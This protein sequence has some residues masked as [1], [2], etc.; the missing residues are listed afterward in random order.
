MAQIT[1]IYLLSPEGQRT[2]L[3]AGRNSGEKQVILLMSPDHKPPTP[4][5]ELLAD[6]T[7]K[8]AQMNEAGAGKDMTTVARSLIEAIT[9]FAKVLDPSVQQDVTV[10]TATP[11]LWAQ[12]VSIAKMD[13]EGTCLLPIRIDTEHL[14]ETTGYTVESRGS[15]GG[16]R[17]EVTPQND[18]GNRY[19]RLMTAAEL[20]PPEV[21]RQKYLKELAS[22]RYEEAKQKAAEWNEALQKEERDR[23][24]R[25]AQSRLDDA[26]DFAHL[27]EVQRLAALVSAQD[28]V[29]LRES[30]MLSGVLQA[31][32][33]AK[34]RQVKDAEMAWVMAHGSEYLQRLYGSGHPDETLYRKERLALE[35][36]GWK[37]GGKDGGSRKPTLDELRFYDEVCQR[38]VKGEWAPGLS[39]SDL[40][41][42]AYPRVRLGIT[43]DN[44]FGVPVFTFMGWGIYLPLPTT[45]SEN[46]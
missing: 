2:A 7:Q 19:A 14:T 25:E 26:K 21:G 38:I 1:V 8:A 22:I 34:D 30:G 23:T 12:A 4:P 5:A 27:P 37:F 16:T 15:Y 28:I 29:A 36:P 39:A 31:I 43:S 40:A 20:I 32:S 33:R 9:L 42:K 46:V 24:L 17:F 35:L 6:I 10:E 13:N 18:R 3:A 11:E 45:K 41:E 44:R